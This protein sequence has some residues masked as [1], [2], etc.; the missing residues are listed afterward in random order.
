ML[1]GEKWYYAANREYL[2]KLPCFYTLALIVNNHKVNLKF[3]WLVFLTHF[4]SVLSYTAEISA[5]WGKQ[6]GKRR[7]VRGPPD[8]GVEIA[9]MTFLNFP[10]LRSQ[11]VSQS[12]SV[13]K[14]GVAL[15][16]GG[17]AFMHRGR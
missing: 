12:L 9:A 7:G 4:W 13:E 11:S 1:L 17:E 2:K 3:I 15:L 14:E 10:R 8:H 6:L 5:S 16:R